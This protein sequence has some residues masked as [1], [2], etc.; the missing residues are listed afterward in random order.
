MD[1]NQSPQCDMVLFQVNQVVISARLEEFK[2]FLELKR[3]FYFT[4]LELCYSSNFK[5][6][7][8]FQYFEK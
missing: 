1:S 6:L 3:T 4:K 8:C 2:Y 5:E 7:F